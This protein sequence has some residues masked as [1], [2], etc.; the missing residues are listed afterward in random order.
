MARK[1][2]DITEKL[3]FEEKPIIVIKGV[4]LKVNDDAETVLRI[5]GFL[6]NGS[7]VTPGE[8]VEMVDLLFT[9]E[10]GEKLKALHLNFND[11]YTVINYAIDFITGNAE[12]ESEGELTTPATT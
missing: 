10:S 5:M 8:I 4:E 1:I 2:V 11:F 9:E 12:E 7:D 6:N 3:S